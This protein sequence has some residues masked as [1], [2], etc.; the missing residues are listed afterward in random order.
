M[1]E[2]YTKHYMSWDLNML[3]TVFC[4]QEM[5]SLSEKDKH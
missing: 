5:F 4:S 3:K 2:S 1:Y